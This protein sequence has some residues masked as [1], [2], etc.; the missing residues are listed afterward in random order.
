MTDAVAIL[1]GLTS[2]A[3]MSVAV[4]C[5]WCVLLL[6]ARLQDLL[7]AGNPRLMTWALCAGLML[8]SLRNA[9][10]LALPLPT[11]VGSGA[12]LVGGMFVGM[13]AS[14][15]G[16]ILEVAPVLMRRFRLG[17]VSTGVRW[18]IMLAKGLGAVAATLTFT[19]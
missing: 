10:G 2:G 13:L 19:L 15:L 16:E 1:I 9:L 14:A 5:V 17:N 7:R 11:W 6:P 18:T 12:L 8:A 4:S 3:A